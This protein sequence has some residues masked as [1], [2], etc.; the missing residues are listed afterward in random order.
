VVGIEGVVAFPADFLDV[1]QARGLESLE[2]ACRGRPRV[3]EALCEL[4]SGHRATARVQG[5][6]D[7]ATAF[8]GE[9]PEDRFELIEL[10]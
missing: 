4:A 9:G 5:D 6:Q 8:V 3:A 1:D 2:M 7:V 10:A